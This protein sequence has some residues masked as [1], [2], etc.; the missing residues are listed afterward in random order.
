M[1]KR[2]SKSCATTSH[3]HSAVV[4]QMQKELNMS[5]LEMEG[6]ANFTLSASDCI[7]IPEVL[8]KL[9]LD[10]SLNVRQKVA[11]SHTLG[12]FRTDVVNK[13]DESSIVVI[14]IP[15]F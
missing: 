1:A 9:I 13:Q 11:L 7:D 4:D 8:E 12:M 10:E 2:K 6:I 5:D 3:V 14:E 15:K